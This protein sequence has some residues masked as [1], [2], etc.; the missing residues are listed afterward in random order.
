MKNILTPTMI[1]EIL[2]NQQNDLINN[3]FLSY[4]SENL[5]R[6]ITSV[7]KKVVYLPGDFI[8]RPG[9]VASEMFFIERGDVKILADDKLTIVAKLHRGDYFGEV[10]VLTDTK[11]TSFVQAETICVLVRLKKRDLD[12]IVQSYPIVK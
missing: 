9:E 7:V 4:G 5:V 10:A 12:R 1:N 11:R 3:M 6:E 8:I 2:Y